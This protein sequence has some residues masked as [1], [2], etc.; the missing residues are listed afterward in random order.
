[1]KTEERDL[2]G[3][4]KVF[5]ACADCVY[6]SRAVITAEGYGLCERSQWGMI[7]ILPG[8]VGPMCE[9][10]ERREEGEA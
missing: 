2:I 4:M 5:C 9:T 7:V 10:Y 6:R 3:S 1:M 8:E